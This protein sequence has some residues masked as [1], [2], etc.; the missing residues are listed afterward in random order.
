MLLF[1]M[2]ARGYWPLSMRWHS[3]AFLLCRYRGIWMSA[4]KYGQVRT[5]NGAIDLTVPPS[6]E[7][8]RP[9]MPQW[10]VAIGLYRL[11]APGVHAMYGGTA[12]KSST[13][14]RQR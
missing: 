1:F 12:V 4:L 9:P 5:A 2:L 6:I 7:T 10:Q 8:N 14:C 13:V 3:A 11:L